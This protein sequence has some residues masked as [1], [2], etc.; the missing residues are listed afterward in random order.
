M[1]RLRTTVGVEVYSRAFWLTFAVK[2]VLICLLVFGALSG[3]QQFEG[4]VFLWRLV[5]Y[6]IAALLVPITWGLTGRR[7]SYPYTVDILL[8]LPC[9]IDT[10]GNTLDLYD[11]IWWWDD[12]NHL[13]NWTLLSGA[14][15]AL[16]WRNHVRAWGTLA[17]VAGF[18]ATTAIVWEIAEY[19][20]FIRNSSEFET[21]YIDT[22]ADLALGYRLNCCR[23]NGRSCAAR[24][25]E[26][27]FWNC[28]STSL[29][30]V[31]AN[32]VNGTKYVPLVSN[33]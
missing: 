7:A 27:W 13:V 3:L 15:G 10:V 2:A 5:T 32:V 21:A 6:P 4:K 11:T 8:T 30:T 16:A 22:L 18:G 19:V 14:I 24:R 1:R 17:Y 28:Q 26:R 31:A 29:L 20:A 33:M 23:C 25:E 9:L 12:A